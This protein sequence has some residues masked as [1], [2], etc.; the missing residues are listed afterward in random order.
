M[1]LIMIA[2]EKAQ[3]NNE[4]FDDEY[5]EEVKLCCRTKKGYYI[6]RMKIIF[7]RNEEETLQPLRE[8]QKRR[9]T[10]NGKVLAALVTC[11]L[12]HINKYGN[13]NLSKSKYEEISS[14]KMRWCLLKKIMKQSEL[15]KC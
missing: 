2:E 12:K 15:P 5:E 11:L 14:Q 3:P 6:C 1:K 4:C 8:L 7:Q 9:L 10:V 13:L